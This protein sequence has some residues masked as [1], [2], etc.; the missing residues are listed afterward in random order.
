MLDS[1]Q[2]ELLSFME[3]RFWADD[4]HYPSLADCLEFTNFY[5]G[6]ETTHG[7]SWIA[8]TVKSDPFTSACR[9]RGLPSLLQTDPRWTRSNVKLAARRINGDLPPDPRNRPTLT[10]EQVLAVNLVSNLHD[11]RSLTSKLKSINLDTKVWN[12]WLAQ[13]P[14]NDYFRGII[15][16]KFG[17]ADID[18][19]IAISQNIQSGDLQSIKYY[20]ELTG[21]YRPDA[22]LTRSLSSVLASLMEILAKYVPT[23][24]LTRVADEFEG[25]LNP[26][27]PTNVSSREVKSIEE[28]LELPEPLISTASPVGNLGTSESAVGKKA[29]K[30]PL[31]EFSF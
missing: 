21:I 20:H 25:V 31:M 2:I 17:Q 15:S 23:D 11:R 19:Q 4:G 27:Q 26:G 22:E 3:E 18:A 30:P 1:D 14:F 10:A 16:R 9:A 12:G 7:I 24:V 13:K 5:L 29:V 28:F 8:K 6:S